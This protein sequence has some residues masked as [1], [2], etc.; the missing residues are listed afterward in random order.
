MQC[1]VYSYLKQREI[2]SKRILESNFKYSK[3][4]PQS[5]LK[6]PFKVIDAVVSTNWITQ[7][8]SSCN[9][10]KSVCAV[11]FA[12]HGNLVLFKG[13][14]RAFFA[15]NLHKNSIDTLQWSLDGK[16]LFAFV[17]CFVLS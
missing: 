4:L 5:K 13:E 14:K 12:L 1:N 16:E 15:E 2:Q 8:I 7:C 6:K 11:S 17:S 3:V 10:D 9:Q